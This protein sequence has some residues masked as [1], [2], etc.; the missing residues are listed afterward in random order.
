MKERS[1]LRTLENN[2]FIVFFDQIFL[3]PEHGN[4]TILTRYA[5]DSFR[6]SS[7]KNTRTWQMQFLVTYIEAESLSFLP[8][9]VSQLL[10]VEFLLVLKP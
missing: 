9:L 7:V 3:E 6:S 5:N 2:R 10:N 4:S 1:F 8:P